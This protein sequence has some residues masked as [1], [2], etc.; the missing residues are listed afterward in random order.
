MTKIQNGDH[1]HNDLAV[2][3]ISSSL[4]S[5]STSAKLLHP[6]PAEY[7]HRC[8]D[9]DIPYP[10]G[11]TK[12]CALESRACYDKDGRRVNRNWPTL[13]VPPQYTISSSKNK[14]TVI[15]SDSYAYLYGNYNNDDNNY[16]T[17]CTTRCGSMA[18]VSANGSCSGIVC[19]QIDIPTGLK[20]TEIT[21]MSFDNHTKCKFNFS[22]A[23]LANFPEERL[24]QVLEW[25]VSNDTSYG[26]NAT[27]Q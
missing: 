23:Y 26:A 24:S 13:M 10:F 2:F 12:G 6:L 7:D 5:S 21:T 17:G 18:R 14:F 25:A 16:S 3:L 15:G 22:Q 11:T 1:G 9:V 27:A 4:S 19:C 20:N 8:G